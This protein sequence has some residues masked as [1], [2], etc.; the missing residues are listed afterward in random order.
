MIWMTK[1]FAAASAGLLLVCTAYGAQQASTNR[2]DCAAPLYFGICDPY[3]P[4]TIIRRSPDAKAI[5]VVNTWPNGPA[6]RSGIC[7]GDK[8]I[9]VNGIPVPGNTWD[10]LLKQIVSPV[11]SPIDL[12][13]VR[14]KQEMDFHFDRARESTLAL[15]SHKKFMLLRLLMDGLQPATVPAELTPEEVEELSRFYD[16][17]DRRVG[18]KFVDGMDVPEGTPEEQIQKLQVTAF[19]GP[20]HERWA[21]FTRMALGENAYSAGFNAVLLKNPEEVLV[22]LVLPDSPAQRAGLFP[23]DQILEVSGH[24]VFGLNEDQLSDLILKPDEQREVVLKFRRGPSTVSPKIETQKIKEIYDATPYQSLGGYP[25]QTKPDTLILGFVLLY[26]ENPREAMVDEVD[27]PSPA[28]DAGLHVGDRILA[29]NAVP[30][31]QINRQQLGEM[32]QPKGGSELR[33]EVSRLGKKQSFQI[34]PVTYAQAEAKIGRKITKKGP[35]PEH[36][37]ES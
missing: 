3:V 10:Q 1:R 21:G 11:P 16:G 32:L 13:V 6:E 29:V 7:P 20:E 23:G 5:D 4:G 26:A 24:P 9:A 28:F 8:I 27:Y 18:F 35:V 14:G 33:L 36:C 15:L 25:D 34:K 12:K 31:E 2:Q 30:V 17:V 19:E 37:P 22:N